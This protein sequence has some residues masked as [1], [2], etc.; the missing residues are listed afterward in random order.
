MEPLSGDGQIGVGKG[1]MPVCAMSHASGSSCEVSLYGAQLLSWKVDGKERLFLSDTSKFE[2]GAPIRGGVPVCWPQF[3]E[4]GALPKH[5]VART[6]NEW[7]IAYWGKLEDSESFCISLA[8]AYNDDVTLTM[9]TTLHERS[10]EQK[11]EVHNDSEKDTFSFTT[12]LHSY[13]NAELPIV[14]SGLEGC[15]FQD[16]VEE[17][18]YSEATNEYITVDGQEIDR[19]YHNSPA[20]VTFGD[21]VVEKDLGFPDT[22]VWNIGHEKLPALEDL[23]SINYVCVETAYAEEP[24]IIKP[25]DSWSGSHTISVKK[26][27]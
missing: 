20:R 3:A 24:C 12:A 10:I 18:K 6:H 14:I 26:V 9:T 21:L 11:M 1:D 16:K 5:G 15:A 19:I 27:E 2:V 4:K 13:F 7:S 8:M 17:G 22:V 23:S 25:N